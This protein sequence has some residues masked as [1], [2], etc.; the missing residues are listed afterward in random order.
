[1]DEVSDEWL[2]DVLD[3]AI[4]VETIDEADTLRCSVIASGEPDDT[5]LDARL[6][7]R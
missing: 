1:M 6:S 2:I 5:L 3:E 4:A 7:R